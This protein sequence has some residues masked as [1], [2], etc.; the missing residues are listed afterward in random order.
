[1]PIITHEESIKRQSERKTDVK[2]EKFESFIYK[3]EIKEMLV[4][5]SV[6]GEDLQEQ[7]LQDL[8]NKVIS[9]QEYQER[10]VIIMQQFESAIPTKTVCSNPKRIKIRQA[11]LQTILYGEMNNSESCLYGKTYEVVAYIAIKLFRDRQGKSFNKESFEKNIGEKSNK[12]ADTVRKN[13]IDYINANS[14]Y[15]SNLP[16]QKRTKKRTKKINNTIKKRT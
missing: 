6:T 13:V 3:N 1:M 8:K 7:L 11:Y 5:E 9:Y 4:N 2:M 16:K 14:Y 10:S 15:I 12:I